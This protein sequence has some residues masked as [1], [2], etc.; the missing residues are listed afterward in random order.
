MHEDI[1]K[2]KTVSMLLPLHPILILK[3]KDPVCFCNKNLVTI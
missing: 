3:P 2:R 1:S